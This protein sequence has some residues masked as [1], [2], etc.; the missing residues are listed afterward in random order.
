MSRLELN[1]AAVADLLTGQNGPVYRAVKAFAE[2]VVLEVKER[3]PEGFSQGGRRETGRLKKDM[4]IRSDDT[5]HSGPAF[6][7]GTDP[8][9]PKDNFHYA[10]RVH[11]GHTGFLSTR[12]VMRFMTRDGRWHDRYAVKKADAVP[13]LYEA[14]DAVN[15][16]PGVTYPFKLDKT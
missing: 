8:F 15:A 3:G 11:R 9:N 6:T 14:V 13:F 4:S 12:G 10:E 16:L 2:A 1:E 5:T 7:V